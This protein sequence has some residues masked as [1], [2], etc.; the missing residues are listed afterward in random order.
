MFRNFQAFEW[1]QKMYI[2]FSWDY[3]CKIGILDPTDFA[4]TRILI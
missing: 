1:Y 4:T 3:P 2:K